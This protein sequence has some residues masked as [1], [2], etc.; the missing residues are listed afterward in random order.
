[1]KFYI[2]VMVLKIMNR[3]RNDIILISCILIIAIIGFLIYLGITPKNNLFVYVY[4][5]KELIEIIDINENKE[6]TVNEVIIIIGNKEVYV[7]TSAC[8]DQIC[9]HQGKIKN[10][11]QTIT[12]LPQ[13]VFIQIEGNGVDVGI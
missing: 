13:R 2:K 9:V 8:S 5:D 11:G 6:I 4:N 12:C 1:M 3:I 10:A 7:K